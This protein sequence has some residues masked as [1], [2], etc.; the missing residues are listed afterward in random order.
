[1][2]ESK[3]DY[4]RYL[5]EDR[6]A[7]GAWTRFPCLSDNTMILLTDPCYRFQK[8]LRKLEFW[9]N[10]RNTWWGRPYLIYLRKKFQ[11]MSVRMGL[12]IPVNVFGEGLCIVHYGSIVV[13]RHARIGRYCTIHSGVNIGGD[14]HRRAATIGD[15]CFIG[16][17]AKI[18]KPVTLGDQ[19]SIG[20]NAVVN[21][22]FE[23]DGI[24][25]AG[26][27]AKIVKRADGAEA[28]RDAQR[29]P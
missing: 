22:D 10:C 8:L 7:L 19:V 12:S 6:K 25:L 24:V 9:T 11:C 13:S 3:E 26:V 28:G 5:Q 29:C 1:M 14:A 27:P 20:A 21:D 2:I 15:H 17:G 23:G 16:P 4:I 18:I